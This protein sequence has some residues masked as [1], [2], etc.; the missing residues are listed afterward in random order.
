MPSASP[1]TTIFTYPWDL[2]DDGLDRALD[3]IQNEAHLKGVSLAVAY[4]IGTYF[5]PHNPRRKIFFGEDGMVLFVPEVQR[6]ATTKM[7]P[8]VGRVVEGRQWLHGLAE[9]IHK[10]SLQLTFWTVYCYNHYLARTYLDCAQRDALGNP[11]LAHLCPANPEVRRYALALSEDLAVNYRPDA[12]YLESLGYLPFGYGYLGGKFLTPITPRAEFLL[13]LCFCAHCQKA[14]DLGGDSARFQADVADWLE[15]ELPRMPTPADQ[16]PVDADWLNTAFDNRLQHYLAARGQQATS[17]YEEVVKRIKA[18][19][20]LV[21]S[22]CATAAES[23]H[24]GL[25]SERVNAVTDR[26]GIGVPSRPEEV[27]TRR[28]GLAPGRQLLAN[29]QPSHASSEASLVQTVG[30]A[31]RAGVDGFTFY[32]YGLIRRE[33]LRWIGAACRQL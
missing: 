19:G 17:L 3:V 25:V 29:I 9:G 30:A 27:R 22:D 14:A 23:P 1:F 31:R 10:R 24:S 26:L 8:R 28:A 18:A 16:A 4:H 21:E 20:G 5:L 11:H 6:W 13:G 32:N 2:H 12:F 33:Q 15:R 7:R